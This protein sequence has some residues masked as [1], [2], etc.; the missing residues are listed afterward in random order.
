M[1]DIDWPS[2]LPADISRQGFN[3]TLPNNKISSSVDVGPA[4]TRKRFTA[5]TSISNCTL[6][7]SQSELAIF[8]TFYNGTTQSGVNYFNRQEPVTEETIEMRFIG[9]PPKCVPDGAK[10]RVTFQLENKL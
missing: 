5:N 3:Q 9:N 2:T 4:K 7:L 1:A 8:D 10:Y 6:L